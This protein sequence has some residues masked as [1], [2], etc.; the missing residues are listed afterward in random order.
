M[1]DRTSAFLVERYYLTQEH[2]VATGNQIY[3]MTKLGQ[4]T[5]A[6]TLFHDQFYTLEK[7]IAAYLKKEVVKHPMWKGYLKGVKGIGPT[8][9]AA[10]LSSIDITRAQH[11]SSVWKYCGLSVDPETGS[12]E[13]RTKGEKIS[14]NPFLK[15][16]C[17]LIGESFVKVKGEYRQVYDTSKAFYQ[18]KFPA[19]VDSGRKTKKGTPI[20]LYT[21]GHIHSMAKRR[22]AKMFLSHFWAKWRE[23]E[24]LPVSEPFGHRIGA[25]A[26]ETRLTDLEGTL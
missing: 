12:A 18:M 21:P 4:P 19:I 16:T 7:N 10:L 13:R 25:L 17:W 24:G 15:K 8:F 26:Q 22:A 2:R 1:L 6:L 5:D 9:A 23:M 20:M 3:A 11:A 14:W